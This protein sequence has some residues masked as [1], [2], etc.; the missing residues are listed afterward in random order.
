MKNAIGNTAMKINGRRLSSWVLVLCVSS[1]CV[2]CAS[3]VCCSAEPCRS[4][5]QPGQRPG[6]YTAVA[7]TGKERGQS[8]CYICETG[9]RPAA[10][11]F[12]RSMTEP[13]AKLVGK[14]D[15]ALA[16]PNPAEFRAWV[17]F[18]SDDQPTFDGKVVDWA[19]QNLPAVLMAWYP[20]Q[21]GGN[22]VADVLLGDANPAG[23][24]P[25]TFYSADAK[26]PA[27]DDYG[28]DGRTYRYYE[29]QALYPFGHGLS[30]TQFGYSGLKL[31]RTKHSF[32]DAVALGAF[33]VPGDGSLD[34]GAIVQKFADYGYE[35]WFV[36]EA[37]QDPRKNPPLKMAE[38]GY[39]ELMR[40]M[41]AA[42][43]T[44]ETQ[45]FP[46]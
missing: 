17:T 33:T 36:V 18:L 32:L 38:V 37:E 34:F 2:L 28:M 42:G 12:A 16:D 43:Y 23:R 22:A 25:V 31:D 45:S 39:A 15:Q 27:F 21:R 11:I 5:L 19:K 46:A 3:V 6:P 41:T 10:V 35:G 44:V 7:A 29:G 13:L 8:Y 30:Y 24:L 14:L 4:G 26:L 20:G 40:V 9:D 1:L